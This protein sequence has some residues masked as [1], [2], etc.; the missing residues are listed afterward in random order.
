MQINTVDSIKDRKQA[1]IKFYGITALVGLSVYKGDR[2]DWV[3]NAVDSILN[4]THKDFLLVI[5]VDGEVAEEI[6]RFLTIVEMEQE[7]VFLLVNSKNV[8]LSA[9]MNRIIDWSIGLQ[10]KCFFRMDA[11][12]IAESNR[13]EVQSK[14]LESNPQVDVLGSALEEINEE[15]QVVGKRTL[16]LSHEEIVGMLPKRCPIN[17][18]TVVIRFSVFDKGFRYREDL[19]NTQDYFFWIELVN[20]GFKFA[21]L[22][23]KLL[24]FRRADGFY[25]RRGLSKSVNEFKARFYAM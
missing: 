7:N 23:D 17:H 19:E 2:F 3:K 10:A 4:Q 20:H 11:D 18:P 1:L 22:R 8:G 21:N 24:K 25:K 12:D 5:C 9:S 14:Y 13:L 15:G 6:Y 16:P